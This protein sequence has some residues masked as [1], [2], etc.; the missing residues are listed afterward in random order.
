MNIFLPLA[1]FS[2]V[3]VV[4]I[5]SLWWLLRGVLLACIQ[6]SR[7]PGIY[8]ILFLSWSL[9]VSSGSEWMIVY[10]VIGKRLCLG[11]LTKKA[12][13][14]CQLI[15]LHFQGCFQVCPTTFNFNHSIM[16]IEKSWI[17]HSLHIYRALQC[18][19]N[20]YKY[21]EYSSQ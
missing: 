16:R 15:Y 20:Y 8:V 9:W 12:S 13:T 11:P 1:P 21:R 5:F 14:I 3:L 18:S 7:C 4:W 2:K 19:R 17:V 10:S 6:S